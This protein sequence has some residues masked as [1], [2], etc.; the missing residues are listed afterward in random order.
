MK[1]C[2][3]CQAWWENERTVC[4]RCCVKLRSNEAS[5]E[6][7]EDGIFEPRK[8]RPKAPTENPQ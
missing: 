2:P 6:D 4:P 7:A 1:Q 5:S 8:P 3:D